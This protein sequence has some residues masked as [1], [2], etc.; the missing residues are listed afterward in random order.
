M[1]SE[2]HY[3]FRFR[4]LVAKTISA[5]KDLLREHNA[6]WWG[7][8]KCPTEGARL[9]VWQ[10]L[11]EKASVRHPV[12]VGL[13]DSGSG[14]VY[15]ALVT[16]V[17]PPEEQFSSEPPLISLPEDELLLVPE[18]Y[19]N[20]P[21]SRAWMR[22]VEIEEKHI[23]FFGSYSF[24]EPPKLYY[25]RK[26]VL[27]RL[28]NKVISSSDE[29]R[30]MDTTIWK[31]RPRQRGDLDEKI[32]LT[33]QALSTPIAYAP[34]EVSS[35]IVLHITDPHF[36]VGA[37]R[38]QHVWRLQTESNDGRN[39][40]SEAIHQAL[41]KQA[42]VGLIVVTGD[43]TFAGNPEEFNEVNLSLQR[44][45]GLFD[46]EQDHLVVIP[47][48]HDIQWWSENVSYSEN[49]EVKRAEAEAKKNYE[50][51]YFQF[52]RHEPDKSLAMGRRFILPCG[53]VL[54]LCAVNS[55]ALQ[56]GRN[57]LAG[58]GFVEKAAFQ[59]V[60]HELG[61]NSANP[62]SLALRILAIHHHLEMTEDLENFSDYSRGFGMAA[63]ALRIKRMAAN[64]GIQLALHGHKHRPFIWSSPIYE[65]VESV[66][67]LHKLGHLS[68]LGGGSAGSKETELGCNYFNLISI[69]GTE[70]KVS[71]YKSQKN[72]SPFSKVQEV[73]ASFYLSKERAGL[74]LGDW[75][76][77]SEN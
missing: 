29:L 47:G 20:S 71:L 72:V 77:S 36:A 40:L 74:A 25:Y 67:S 57:F 16:D 18:Y 4:D 31:V 61:W 30:G 76:S 10:D 21:Y 53:I 9:K 28:R 64:Y 34:I 69:N 73:V 17:I 49:A 41:G 43:L 3:L 51:F 5:H 23:K 13:F 39:T 58:M 42:K 56:T 1:N 46:L 6:C 59:K 27:D 11:K 26:E 63:D 35:N 19:R 32:V 55:S 70:I 68:I 60:A 22:L 33:T 65:P 7:W 38:D 8:W 62:G 48:N 15:A 54:E 2:I 24:S 50:N 44:L 14:N 52:F 12:R 66:N 37:H 45:R 75:K